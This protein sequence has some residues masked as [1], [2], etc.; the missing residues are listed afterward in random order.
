MQEA[1]SAVHAEWRATIVSRA[2]RRKVAFAFAA[3][4]MLAVVGFFASRHALEDRGEH[5]VTDADHYN[6]LEFPS[7]VSV[8]LD[9]N[10]HIVRLSPQRIVLRNGAVYVDAAPGRR[11]APQALQIETPAGSVSHVGTQYEVRLLPAATRIRVREGSVELIGRVPVIVPAR[12]QLVVAESGLV[13][14]TGISPDSREWEWTARAAPV[15]EIEGRSLT[16]FLAWAGREL[17]CE[18]VY[19]TPD[20]QAEAARAILSGSIAGLM[21][22]EALQAVL[23]TTRLRGAQLNGRVL[24]E[25]Q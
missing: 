9:H 4:V 22:A 2:R 19:S 18:I 5:I 15:F 14:R 3:S 12:E 23:P 7:G 6:V 8:R 25:W 17:G 13:T 11:D 21:P 10:T 1:R 16:E 20:V 24:I